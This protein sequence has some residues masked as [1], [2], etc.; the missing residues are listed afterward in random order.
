MLDAIQTVVGR[1]VPSPSVDIA[2]ITVIDEEYEA[3]RTAFELEESSDLDNS[4]R[5]YASGVVG[6]SE[7]GTER[8]VVCY[9]CLTRGTNSANTLTSLVL[10][11]WRP[12]Y[13]LLVGIAGGVAGRD[14]LQ[15]GD[16]VFHDDIKYYELEKDTPDGRRP[17][18]GLPYV[19]SPLLLDLARKIARQ[20]ADAWSIPGV[21]RPPGVGGQPKAIK[22]Q[23]LCGEK[24]WS[25]P[26][27]EDLAALLSRYDKA[28]AIEMESYGVGTAAYEH[29]AYGSVQ[30]LVVKGICDF[31]NQGPNQAT[32]DKWKSF[33]A[34]SAAR[35]ARELVL[36]IGPSSTGVADYQPTS[37]LL[38]TSFFHGHTDQLAAVVDSIRGK[39]KLIDVRG[40]MDIGKTYLVHKAISLGLEHRSGASVRLLS[41]DS[42][43]DAPLEI[44]AGE[45]RLNPESWGIHEFDE[46][47]P[48]DDLVDTIL[49]E[50]ADREYI[51]VIDD[52]DLLLSEG[53]DSQRKAQRFDADLELLLLRMVT[54]ES[55][56]TVILISEVGPALPDE[57]Q[58]SPYYC[59]VE[60]HE[61]TR[62]E[63]REWLADE[64][65]QLSDSQIVDIESRIGST[66]VVI[67]NL[68]SL[69]KTGIG[70][71]KDILTFL[72]G[73]RDQ[74][75][76]KWLVGLAEHETHVLQTIAC[77]RVPIGLPMLR[78]VLDME[79]SS[80]RA[81]LDGLR[82]RGLLLVTHRGLVDL[83][84]A[85]RKYIR[86]QTQDGF[87]QTMSEKI[88]AAYLSSA[89]ALNSMLPGVADLFREALY[90]YR[91]AS[92]D[93]DAQSVF[94]EA[95]STLYD[96]GARAFISGDY[97]A[98]RQSAQQLLDLSEEIP[99]TP[100]AAM[101]CSNA[102]YYVA[103]AMDHAGEPT[104]HSI[105]QLWLA[106]TA[107]SRNTKA[108]MRLVHS[109]A[110]VLDLEEVPD[111]ITEICDSATA[112]LR[113]LSDGGES[114]YYSPLYGS[115]LLHRAQRCADVSKRN[116]LLYAVKR[117]LEGLGGDKS[118]EAARLEGRYHSSLARFETDMDSRE[119]SLEVALHAID[120]GITSSAG[121]APR[122]E[123]ERAFVLTDLGFYVRLTDRSHEY[124]GKASECLTG[125]CDSYPHWPRPL[126]LLGR[127]KVLSAKRILSREASLHLLLE[128][129]DLSDRL[130]LLTQSPRERVLRAWAVSEMADCPVLRK[131]DLAQREQ[132]RREALYCLADAIG[133]EPVEDER[134]AM[135]F[136]QSV[137]DALTDK[138]IEIP[139]KERASLLRSAISRTT[140]TLESKCQIELSK[141][142]GRLLV[143][144]AREI[145]KDLSRRR[146]DQWEAARLPME[147]A[148]EV[149][150]KACA[151]DPVD[152]HCKVHLANALR[153]MAFRSV[154]KRSFEQLAGEALEEARR[155]TELDPIE[156]LGWLGLF[157]LQ[158][159]LFQDTDAYKT[160]LRYLDV[161]TDDQRALRSAPRLAEVAI[162]L[163]YGQDTAYARAALASAASL[164]ARAYD[165]GSHSARLFVNYGRILTAQGLRDESGAV[166]GRI[167]VGL[168]AAGN[169]LFRIFT[170][171]KE[172]EAKLRD[173]AISEG[174]LLGIVDPQVWNALG[175]Y[176]KE[177][178]DFD[179]AD[180][181]YQLALKLNR[182]DVIA[183][184]NRARLI[185]ET[186]A[187][188]RLPEA[189]KYIQQA[190]QWADW[191]F[192]RWV[193]E[194]KEE[195][196][197]LRP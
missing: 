55:R 93:S 91:T 5:G 196:R 139:R 23:L 171:L 37:G 6:S 54:E 121:P 3:V 164:C 50:L 19:P 180:T 114:D 160:F 193:L 194:M 45:L 13:L 195:L 75:Y 82:S 38:D 56:S 162:H 123:L 185:A 146:E 161:E 147:R 120:A 17:R 34:Q 168:G 9:Q 71:L 192:R 58:R 188:P 1:G 52:C 4:Q 153:T 145:Q 44:I 7:R 94:R 181:C 149:L 98:A 53:A 132:W 159:W 41:S 20:G 113:E 66:P 79:E 90:H 74:Q 25:D 76:G 173:D 70:E 103:K 72:E 84:R 143:A 134:I 144:R 150:R 197:S 28:L 47:S 156:P 36:A 184:T 12:Q 81:V 187:R 27:S 176:F 163:T 137:L 154:D 190:S 60:L 126:R 42:L 177:Y 83:S 151:L 10:T 59:T 33:A 87:S 169:E 39:G 138:D 106:V 109:L 124:F 175:T 57:I 80:L 88:A 40:P 26:D 170:A 73:P 35:F 15:L 69:L 107:D 8:T 51:V 142:Q 152:P 125:L 166:V 189:E 112:K 29:H 65:F 31:V 100:S 155:A 136:A 167:L 141:M 140:V 122:L 148:V 116:T 18:S 95:L 68:C 11:R 104:S 179:S 165:A 85:F 128:A 174:A 22:G 63:I 110:S 172:G 158:K 16:V 2:I 191:P 111:D 129:V 32:R 86:R 99:K 64:D 117:L 102:H 186:G 78:E 62:E 118:R 101:L 183:L 127:L 97:Q 115:L 49:A 48:T 130:E 178:G 135:R 92:R 133:N 108:W 21:T 43:A 131:Q 61:L 77:T 182:R 105:E 96:E 67:G 119:R 14:E 157:S 24:L 30:F 46:S 89:R